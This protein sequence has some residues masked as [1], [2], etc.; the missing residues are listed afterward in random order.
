MLTM[1]ER[2]NSYFFTRLETLREEFSS[3]K[4]TLWSKNQK[5]KT[6]STTN[7]TSK[8]KSMSTSTN[9][10]S[11]TKSGWRCRWPTWREQASRLTRGSRFVCRQLSSI[12]C[13]SSRKFWPLSWWSW[14]PAREWDEPRVRQA[15]RGEWWAGAA[16][17]RCPVYKDR[18]GWQWL[19]WSDHDDGNLMVMVVVVVVVVK[20]PSLL[21][22]RVGEQ[23]RGVG[24]KTTNAGDGRDQVRGP[25]GERSGPKFSSTSSWNQMSLMI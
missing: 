8:S 3:W 25:R 23:V 22:F 11:D 7:W 9:L 14:F 13:P 18:W 1:L 10:F 5:S 19:W 2:H 4:R 17:Q 21:L 16:A 24:S 12:F 6:K 15:K 20:L